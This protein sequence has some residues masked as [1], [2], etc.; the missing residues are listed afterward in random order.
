MKELVR[1]GV[2]AIG[3]VVMAAAMAA[4]CGGGQK[5]KGEPQ[6][7]GGNR[8]MVEWR[9]AEG[10]DQ[11][12]EALL[13]E[14]K[15]EEAE[16]AFLEALG[17]SEKYA[18]AHQGMAAIRFH[19]G[20]VE[21]GIGALRAGLALTP[22]LDGTY[23]RTRILEDLAG[24]LFA[25]GK[26]AEAFEAVKGSVEAQGLPA[27]TAE[28][29]TKIGRARLLVEARRWAEA[30]TEL[31]AARVTGAEDYAVVTV[32]ALEIS[33]LA[34][35][36]ELAKAEAA[37]QALVAKVGGDHPRALEPAFLLALARG[38]LAAAA[39]LLGKVTEMDP[40]AAEKAELALARA[41]KAAGK[42]AEARGYFEGIAKRYLRSVGS[43]QVRRAAA[44]E[45]E[46]SSAR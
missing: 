31:A 40:Y 27:A 8:E 4:G 23:S 18:L 46:A 33:V 30:Q 3:C 32:S 9:A 16:R 42:E 14:G 25:Q 15:L 35:M 29:V 24:A 17:M 11:E 39:A 19:R 10:K 12:A 2:R 37:Y 41:L 20:E 7:T 1:R 21:D 43:A 26:E 38:E 5:E 44:E 22:Q 6:P 28:A 36:G 34:G 45:L 13:N